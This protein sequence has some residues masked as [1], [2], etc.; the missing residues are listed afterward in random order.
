MTNKYFLY[1][2]FFVFFLI[3]NSGFVY[4]YNFIYWDDYALYQHDWNVLLKMF[5][6]TAGFGG[7]YIAS[8]HYVLSNLFNGVMSY[9]L[10][11]L[12]LCFFTSLFVYKISLNSGVFSKVG[13]FWLSL[14]FICFP[15]LSSKITLIVFPYIFSLFLFYFAFYLLSIDLH[16]K[17]LTR[18]VI[19]FLF[20]I[21][22]MF[23]SLLVF[24]SIVLLY[25]YIY[26][27]FYKYTFFGLF[28][29]LRSYADFLLLPIFFFALKLSFMKSNGLY[30]G[31]NSVSIQDFSYYYYHFSNSIELFFYG[32]KGLFLFEYVFWISIFLVF[33]QFFLIRKNSFQFKLNVFYKNSLYVL[34]SFA[35]IFL[36]F[37]PYASVGLSPS[38][39]SVDDRHYFLMPLAFSFFIVSIVNFFYIYKPFRSIVFLLFLSLFAFENARSSYVYYIDGIYQESIILDMKSNDLINE[40]DSFIVGY[41]K[42]NY[43]AYKRYINPYEWNGMLRNVYPDANKAMALSL[44]ELNNSHWLKNL[45]YNANNYIFSEPMNVCLEMDDI[46][47]FDFLEYLIDYDQRTFA[48][49]TEC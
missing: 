29:F 11:S 13:S 26:N 49:F 19:L 24:F 8:L 33:I 41:K 22:F 5:S 20:L 40:N 37:F 48:R 45:Q 21:S 9:R 12:V 42:E 4:N 27:K 34:F 23:N 39:R 25:I 28:A 14:V 36:A 38:P 6:Q 1:F 2:Y 47:F 31:Y 35:L 43:F 15:F 10:I 7:Y 16:K 32:L 44:S 3:S 46:S 30:D 18:V 17:I